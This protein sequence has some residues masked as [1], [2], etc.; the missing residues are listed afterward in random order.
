MLFKFSNLTLILLFSPFNPI[1]FLYLSSSYY[2]QFPF[3][4]Y[5]FSFSPK[6]DNQI[7]DAGAKAVA[8]AFKAN[9]TLSILGLRCKYIQLL[10]SISFFP[11]FFMVYIEHLFSD[12]CF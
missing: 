4:N 10:I 3:K 12:S 6:L 5:V 1:S 7:G 11:K 9:N 8:D 2:I